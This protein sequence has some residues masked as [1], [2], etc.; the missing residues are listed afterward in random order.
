MT[1]ADETT[2]ADLAAWAG[3]RLGGQVELSP[4]AGDGGDRRYFRLEGRGLLALHGPDPRE[5]LAWLTIGRHLWF[6]GLSLPRI[7][8]HN[9]GRGF[10]LLEDLGPRRLAEEPPAGRRGLYLQAAELLARFHA[11]ALDGFSPAWSFQSR[12]YDAALI[13]A[14]EACYFFEAFLRG[15][16]G[17]AKLPR[18]LTAE[19]RAFSRLAAPEPRE[20]V[21]M[22]RD[23]QSRNLMVKNGLVHVLDWQ[24]ARLGPAA[25]DL[26]SL[27]EDPYAEIEAALKTELVA[28]YIRAAGYDAA[29]AARLRRGLGLLAAARLMQAL[30]A[31]GKLAAA[32]KKNFAAPMRPAL[33]RLTAQL[34]RP[35]AAA[36]PLLRDVVNEAAR[37]MENAR[38]AP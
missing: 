12:R 20:C 26:A 29:R 1:K 11:L 28:A 21:L 17:W 4:L 2:R 9:P 36:F 23:Y 14:R 6:K 3:A 24:G 13:Y 37:Q 30:G 5:N 7:Y 18:G 33:K 25:Y 34:S 16:L 38:C 35:E 27:L 10:F 15:Y 19:A 32:G 8:E 22:H 31:Y